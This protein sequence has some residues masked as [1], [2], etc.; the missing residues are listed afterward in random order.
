MTM[1]TMWDVVI[2]MRHAVW[3]GLVPIT[4]MTR[5][6]GTFEGIHTDYNGSLLMLVQDVAPQVISF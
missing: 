2:F 5:V 3:G 4:R 6:I 1:A